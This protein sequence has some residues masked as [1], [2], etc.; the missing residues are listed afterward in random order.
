MELRPLRLHPGSDL[1]RAL[2]DAARTEFGGAAFVVGAIGSLVAARLRF[3][4]ADGESVLAGPHEILTLSGSLSAD[5]A[6]LHMS[7]ADRDGRVAGGHVG[8]GNEV[9]TTAEVLLAP[10]TG[11]QLAREFDPATGYAELVA[12]RADAAERPA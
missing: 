9:R 6:H 3:A 8:Y 10:L 2:E 12:R 11:W 5:G 4:A 1:R 7:V